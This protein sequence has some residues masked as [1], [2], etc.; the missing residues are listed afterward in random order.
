MSNNMRTG[1]CAAL[2]WIAAGSAALAAEGN[3]DGAWVEAGSN[4]AN[5]FVWQDGRWAFREPKDMYGPGFIV[6]GRQ[7]EQV[8]SH[9]R[10]A[11]SVEKQ[12]T[13]HVMLNCGDA[14]GSLGQQPVSFRWTS[15]NEI[16]RFF[17]NVDG[18]TLK[19]Q[20]CPRP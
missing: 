19:Y 15:A 2:A 13:F 4:C 10:I 14:M 11:S 3:L 17:P 7:V 6:S 5:I 1:L 16:E 9:C 20:R 8:F 12:D 18:M